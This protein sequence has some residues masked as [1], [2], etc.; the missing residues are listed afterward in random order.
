[1]DT[2]YENI[3]Q[4]IE[5]DIYAGLYKP[6]KKLPSVRDL[7]IKYTCSKN[8]VVKAYETLRNNH[9]IYSIP[10]SG[11]YIVEKLITNV[12]NPSQVINFSSGNP[13]IGNM[14]TPD[15]KHCLDRAVD[16]YKNN[17]L[18][19]VGYGMTSLREILPKYL[20]NFQ[21]FAPANS[22][23]VNLGIQQALSILTQMP[24]PNGKDLI[25]VEQPTY[26]YFIGF[27]KFIGAK[28][29]GIERDENGIDLNRLEYLFK[30]EKIKF[31]YTIPRNHSPLGTTYSK[32]QRKAIAEL[33]SK[34]DVYIVEDDYF[35]D[36]SLDSKYDPIFTYSDH[37]HHFYLKS[38]SKILP[39]MRIGLIVIP[40]DMLSLFEEYRQVSYYYSYF[41]ASLISQ[42]T[43]EIY[44]RSNI[45]KKHVT[46]ITKEVEEKL[47]Y[48]NSNLSKLEKYG[49]KSMGEKSGFYSY[50]QLPDYVNEY[51]LVEDL[52]NQNILVSLGKRFYLGESFYRKGIRLSIASVNCEEINKGFEVITSQLEK[53]IK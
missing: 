32:V 37:T 27:L 29:I 16:I 34:Y 49:V 31:F 45:L 48:L 53:Y 26:T 39:W 24:F 28:V 8:T 44:I 3:V 47:K 23:F 14:N 18:S 19:T 20:S 2:I 1:M 11:Y 25:L 4:D 50:L 10:Q 41:S 13:I 51:K 52:K 46:S 40:P 15:L 17:S 5:K 38:F 9:I 22:I 36:I 7:S 42:A 6:G 30:N 12:E 35:A 21:V 33:A 43:L